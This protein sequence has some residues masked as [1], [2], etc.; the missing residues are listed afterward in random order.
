MGW[1]SERTNE[2]VKGLDFIRRGRTRQYA[3]DEVAAKIYEQTEV[4]G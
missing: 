2:V 1:G 3:A 4:A